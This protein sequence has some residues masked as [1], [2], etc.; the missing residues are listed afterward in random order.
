ME[1]RHKHQFFEWIVLLKNKLDLYYGGN[2]MSEEERKKIRD[3]IENIIT[4]SARILGIQY[5]YIDYSIISKYPEIVECAN[6]EYTKELITF[7][8]VDL[9]TVI[10]AMLIRYLVESSLIDRN[11]DLIKETYTDRIMKLEP[12]SQE[13][14]N[15]G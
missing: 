9:D 11:T 3:I 14:E 5:K 15:N 12:Y 8:R 7:V 4:L 2:D 13:V 1:S 6:K 10:E